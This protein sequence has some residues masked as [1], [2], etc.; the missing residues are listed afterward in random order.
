MMFNKV[1]AKYTSNRG[2]VAPGVQVSTLHKWVYGWWMAVAGRGAKPPTVDGDG[3]AH[4]WGQMQMRALQVAATSSGAQRLNWGHLIIDEGQ[5][6]PPS[7]YSGLRMI[8]DVA[9]AR[10]AEPRL[11]LTVLADEN[12]RLTPN[13]NSTIDEVR[14]N[15]GLHSDD[16]NVFSLKKNYRN[17]KEIAKFA[18]SFYAGL[19]SGKPEPP[20]RTGE[21]PVVS[22]V[23]SETHDKF[24]TACAEKIAKYAKLRRTEEIAVLVMGNR[25]RA[26]VL[27]RLKGRLEGSG[28]VLQSYASKDEEWPADALQFDT[29]GHLTVLNYNS[30]KGLEFDAVFVV[31]PGKLM[32]GGSSELNVKMA[33][34]VMCSRARTMLNVMLVDDVHGREMLRWVPDGACELESL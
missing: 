25:E 3:W 2:G 12:Q 18:E 16:R 10:G 29:P 17:T 4:D 23:A 13:R 34:Y 30:A 14:V 19:P 8:M 28:V 1:L 6:F 32:N 15:L 21:L 22:L 26:K 20:R 9:N 31:D 33:L 5:D 11:A 7:M 27:N 24:L